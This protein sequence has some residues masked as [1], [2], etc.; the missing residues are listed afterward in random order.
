MD[1]R[2]TLIIYKCDLVVWEKLEKNLRVYRNKVNSSDK[3]S[4]LKILYLMAKERR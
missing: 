1:E 3:V 4:C 2:R